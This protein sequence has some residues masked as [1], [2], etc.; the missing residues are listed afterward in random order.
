MASLLPGENGFHRRRIF[1]DLQ[2]QPGLFVNMGNSAFGIV[3]DDAFIDVGQY[4]GE[5][6]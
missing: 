1:P 6:R 2:E 4:R 5:Q 3:H